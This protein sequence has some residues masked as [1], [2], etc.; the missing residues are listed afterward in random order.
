MAT[1][2]SPPGVWTGQP[3]HSSCLALLIALVWAAWT[4]LGESFPIAFWSAVAFPVLHQF[5]VWLAWRCE[6]RSSA[7]SKTI[8]FRGYLAI[9]F[10]LFG[11]RFLSLVV[12][13]W[14]DRDSLKLQ[15]LPQVILTIILAVLGIYAI[16]RFA[17]ARLYGTRAATI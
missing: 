13:A 7:T 11:G 1:V 8:G 16:Y 9:F 2:D 4:F 10:L 15:V 14:L 12:L 3:L 5:F 6:L 17:R